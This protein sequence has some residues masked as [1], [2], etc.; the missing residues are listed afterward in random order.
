MSIFFVNGALK[1]IK[2]DYLPEDNSFDFYEYYMRFLT[3]STKSI[4]LKITMFD[5]LDNRL[6]FNKQVDGLQVIEINCTP[7]IE[8]FNH[9]R[10]SYVKVRYIVCIEGSDD[11]YYG[12]FPIISNIHEQSLKIV[13]VSGNDNG[14]IVYDIENMHKAVNY[15]NLWE[16]LGS[17]NPDIILHVGNQVYGDH[18]YNNMI[19]RRD[20]NTYNH[21]LI[22]EKYAN[23]YRTAYGEESQGNVMRNSINLMMIDGN[24]IYEYF[25]SKRSNATKNN[26]QF[27]AYYVGGIK[28]YLRYQHQLYSDFDLEI[29]SIEKDGYETILSVVDDFMDILLGNGVIYYD[30]NYGKYT[31]I[32]L[33]QRHCLYHKGIVMDNNQLSWLTEVIK[34]TENKDII[35]VSPRPIGFLNT[36]VAK[37]YGYISNKGRDDLFHPDNYDGTMELLNILNYYSDTKD[38]KLISGKK[39]YINVILENTVSRN[40]LPILEQL[41][42][43]NITRNDEDNSLPK[44]FINWLIKKTNEFEFGNFIIGE[45]EHILNGNSYGLIDNDEISNYCINDIVNQHCNIN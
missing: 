25:G 1:I 32:L 42:T 43:G 38:I 40:R 28:A 37:F 2:Y 45:K 19:G 34:T 27:T 18:I 8:R 16:H 6:E 17:V 29:E 9:Q 41:A 39:T 3:E 11:T 22:F 4:N 13:T 35:V 44:K 21:D 10:L 31:F 23:L 15:F 20:D 12:S 33:D 7:F 5:D 14:D 30:I 36:N 24:E 26:P